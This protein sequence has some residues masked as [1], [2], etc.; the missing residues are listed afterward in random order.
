M[1]TVNTVPAPR[2]WPTVSR[3]ALGFVSLWIPLVL[4]ALVTGWHDTGSAPADGDSELVHYA[5]YGSAVSGPLSAMLIL[6]VL[7]IGARRP[8]RLGMLATAALGVMGALIAFQGVSAALT[9]HEYAP[10]A[11]GTIAGLCF[12]AVGTALLASAARRLL[13]PR[14][15]KGTAAAT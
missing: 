15:A 4:L 5:L 13:T 11:V 3:V 12:F 6:T 14:T 9:D 10:Q 7:A 2:P 1:S 8:G